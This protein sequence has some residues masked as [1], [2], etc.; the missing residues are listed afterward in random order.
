M[1]LAAPRTL[2]MT[3]EES[4][5]DEHSIRL[6][7]TVFLLRHGQHAPDAPDDLGGGLTPLGRCQARRAARRVAEQ[8]IGRL[9]A[10]NMRRARQTAEILAA[11]V[12][13]LVVEIDPDLR[14]CVPSVP[15][16]QQVFYPQ[17]V[18]QGDCAACRERLDRAFERYVET[19]AAGN[20][21]LVAH[22]NAIR[23]L[24]CRVLDLPTDA[25]AKFD[26]NNCGL[27]RV[28]VKTMLGTQVTGLNDIGH[29]SPSMVTFG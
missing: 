29:L 2:A 24:L 14:E 15:P 6:V 8:G 28:D 1:P 11:E 5:T 22:G 27:C 12:P 21:V 9:V 23:Y 26:I 4:P 16:G 18:R 25:W 10:S 13:S 17:G 3:T 7:R 20:T 19:P